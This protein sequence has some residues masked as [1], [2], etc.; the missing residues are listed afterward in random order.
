MRDE[1]LAEWRK[2]KNE[3]SFHVYCKV[4]GG[5]GPIRFRDKIFRQEL[6]LVLEVFRF[7]DQRLFF[8]HP[9][10]D[11]SLIWVHFQSKRQQFNKIEKWGTLSNYLINDQ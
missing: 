6:P 4:S 11:N 2:I 5:I 9:D 1:V 3:H 10:L 7:G 8:T